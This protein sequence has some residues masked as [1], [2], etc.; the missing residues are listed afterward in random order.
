MPATRHN[1][2]QTNFA[3]INPLFDPVYVFYD[4]NKAFYDTLADVQ[5]SILGE[6]TSTSA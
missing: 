4:E 6:D 2:A 1:R 3:Q 5:A